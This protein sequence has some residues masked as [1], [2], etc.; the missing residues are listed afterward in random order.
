M[1]IKDYFSPLDKKLV[2]NKL[3]NKS[4]LAD[5]IPKHKSEENFLLSKNKKL[6]IQNT[7]DLGS[8]KY[9]YLNKDHNINYNNKNKF[10]HTSLNFNNLLKSQEKQEK[11][12]NNDN[13][14]IK[15]NIIN[16]IRKNQDIL[17]LDLNNINNIINKNKNEELK[18][19]KKTSK[20]RQKFNFSNGFQQSPNITNNNNN[21]KIYHHS[22]LRKKFY[23]LNLNPVDNLI[24]LFHNKESKLNIN[25]MTNI[26]ISPTKNARNNLL[27]NNFL[28][29]INKCITVTQ[30]FNFFP[31]YFSKT[32]HQPKSETK[33]FFPY[34]KASPCSNN[35]FLPLSTKK[36]SSNNI[37]FNVQNKK[38]IEL[39]KDLKN[40][41]KRRKKLIGYNYLSIAGKNNGNKKVNEDNYLIVKNVNGCEEIK[42]F[43]VF[44]GH[45]ELGKKISQDVRDFFENYFKND[46]FCSNEKKGEENKGINDYN[47]KVNKYQINAL[48]K[49]EYMLL[50]RKQENEK[51]LN[52]NNMLMYCKTENNNKFKGISNNSESIS[53]IYKSLSTKN[54]SSIYSSFSSI[55]SNLKKKY[56]SKNNKNSTYF[57]SGTTSFLLL[58]FNNHHHHTVH[59]NNFP[60]RIITANLGNC[61]GIL[62]SENNSIKELNTC[63]TP[64][65]PTERTRIESN[66]GEIH[67][68]NNEEGG[69]LRIWFK[70]ENFP[71]LSITRSLGDFEAEPLGLIATPDI[72]EFDID[73]EK[74]KI[75]V[76]GTDGVWVFLGYEKV[77]EIILPFYKEND[78]RSACYKVCQT[79]INLWKVNYPNGIPDVTAI[80]L[81]FK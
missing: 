23:S 38:N 66:G 40:N 9:I 21:G 54:Y 51:N 55:N 61:K 76:F 49:K 35:S 79:A 43:G 74:V 12:T 77:I 4:P 62:I 29:S 59:I 8:N 65:N 26:N 58:L 1:E 63:H 25:T 45:G 69:P 7:E 80:V 42:I 81:F 67:R 30:G 71:G 41:V 10:R 3:T 68:I 36:N 57:N 75:A 17:S 24:P 39:K 11:E 32:K 70:N 34:Q 52:N 47:E 48:S 37:K 44:D 33:I 16:N 64:D 15:N 72:R 53:Q 28:S 46:I 5:L 27:I 19:T 2:L 18:N 60:N 13:K 14:R 73:E 56:Y 20:L 31:L 78:A 50:N 22:K 6:I